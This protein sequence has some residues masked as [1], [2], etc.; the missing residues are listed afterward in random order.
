MYA[1][2]EE[3]LLLLPPT[4]LSATGDAIGALLLP[5]SVSDSARSWRRSS[6]ALMLDASAGGTKGRLLTERLAE[7][8]EADDEPGCCAPAGASARR[9]RRQ[10]R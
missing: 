8:D 7:V 9:Q 3:L 10:R 4:L 5:S 1:G 2:G 6:A